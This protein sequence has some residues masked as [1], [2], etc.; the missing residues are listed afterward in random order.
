MLGTLFTSERYGP[1]L[2]VRDALLSTH[3]H[4]MLTGACTPTGDLVG[5]CGAVHPQMHACL[6]FTDL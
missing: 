3:A 5:C 4:R 1:T 2:A 6:G